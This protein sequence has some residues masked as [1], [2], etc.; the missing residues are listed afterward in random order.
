MFVKAKNNGKISLKRFS[1]ALF[2]N[3]FKCFTIHKVSNKIFFFFNRLAASCG[4]WYFKFPD[5]GV[6]LCPLHWKRGVCNH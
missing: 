1:K 4:M 5:Q 6:N 3:L 2:R